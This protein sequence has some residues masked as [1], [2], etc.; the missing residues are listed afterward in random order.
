MF[1]LGT[2]RILLTEQNVFKKSVFPFFIIK[3]SKKGR[4]RK[5]HTVPMDSTGP[6]SVT[7]LSDPRVVRY[8]T[9]YPGGRPLRAGTCYT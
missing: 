7:L 9:W 2:E 6:G 8:G 4:I 3:T 1:Q 5:N